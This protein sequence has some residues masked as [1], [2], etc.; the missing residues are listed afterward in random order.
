[1][2]VS[3]R[4]N[5]KIVAPTGAPLWRTGASLENIK[6]Y[7]IDLKLLLTAKCYETFYNH[8]LKLFIIS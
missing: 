6:L 5:L 8:N 2:Q 1:M 4:Q 3:Q 7:N